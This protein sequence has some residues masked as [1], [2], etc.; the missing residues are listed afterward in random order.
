[1]ILARSR[2][3]LAAKTDTSKK[4][5]LRWG[6]FLSKRKKLLPRTFGAA[7]G[8]RRKNLG[9]LFAVKLGGGGGQRVKT[10]YVWGVKA[11]S[12]SQRASLR[13][14]VDVA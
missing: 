3:P 8:R 14:A 9:V 11:S 7:A 12:V 1:M 4:E 6:I 13:N 5:V 10:N 2:K